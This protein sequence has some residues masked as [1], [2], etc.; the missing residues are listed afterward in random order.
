MYTDRDT[1]HKLLINRNIK[2]FSQAEDT[3]QGLNGFIQVALGVDGTNAFSDRVLCGTMT[4]D[5][6]AGFTLKEAEKYFWQ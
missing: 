2:H 5:D 1:I 3:P 4:E 6:R